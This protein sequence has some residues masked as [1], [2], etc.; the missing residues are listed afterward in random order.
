MSDLT[1]LY[2]SVLSVKPN[3]PAEK[4][5]KCVLENVI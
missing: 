2:F 1:S 5:L 4:I 3:D